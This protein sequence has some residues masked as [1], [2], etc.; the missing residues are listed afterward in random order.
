MNK[1]YRIIKGIKIFSYIFLIIGCFIFSWL[2][3]FEFSKEN[4]ISSKTIILSFLWLTLLILCFIGIYETIVYKIVIN[5]THIKKTNAL[6]T[7][8]LPFSEIDGFKRAQNY[9]YLIPKNKN[10]KQ[11]NISTYLEKKN[12]WLNYLI[13]N[14]SDLDEISFIKE[15]EKL[16]EDNA[17]GNSQ[18]DRDANIKKAH[19]IAKILN[20]TAWI[21]SLWFL[22]YP[23]PYKYLVLLISAFPII[24][25]FFSLKF[26]N[27]F[28]IFTSD[29]NPYPT[30]YSCFITP[31]SALLIRG[32]L[33]FDVINYNQLWSFS[34]LFGFLIVG[35][36]AKFKFSEFK[37]D[38]KIEFIIRYFLIFIG[39]GC[40]LFFMLILIN[41]SFDY[42]I[43]TE[44]ESRIVNKRISK[45][46]SSPIRYL[47]TIDDW[48]TNYNK[49]KF[50]VDKSLYNNLKEDDLIMVNLYSGLLGIPW[51]YLDKN[52][53][54]LED[55]HYEYFFI[56]ITGAAIFENKDTT[57]NYLIYVLQGNDTMYSFIN[58]DK[59]FKISLALGK[60]YVLGFKKEGF[61]SKHL[62]IDVMEYGNYDEY[63]YGFEFPME[64]VFSK[65]YGNTPSI[66]VGKIK[67]DESSGYMEVAK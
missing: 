33:D 24:G 37:N 50:K 52:D 26:K 16:Y 40:Y 3:F 56:D 8:E 1:E 17:F 43:P 62:I 32:L 36:F 46:R 64:I 11:L 20:Y 27:Q 9:L 54:Y 53:S 66:E 7:K 41:C 61:L 23:T 30:L 6:G 10:Y 59:T 48:H 51:A 34:I 39:S 45:G 38:N 55:M 60:S 14:L 28:K 15:E 12:E 4:A 35:S 2:I 22:F 19:Q 49:K 57:S 47:V 21:C 58:K 67:Y 63:K 42:S 31:I 65:D 29:N 44:Y 25:L 13:S 5:K 18:N